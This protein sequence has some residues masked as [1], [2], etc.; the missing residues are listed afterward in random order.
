MQMGNPDIQLQMQ[1]VLGQ[2]LFYPP[3]VAG[4]PGGKDWIDGASLM[5]RM[6]IPRMVASRE[7]PSIRAKEDDDMEMGMGRRYERRAMRPLDVRVDW[8]QHF[9]SMAKVK[10]EELLTATASLLWQTSNL[11]DAPMLEKYLDTS[12]RETYIQSSFIRLMGSPEYQLC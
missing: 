12:T 1:R 6:Q 2:V 4:W 5:Y 7:M 10:R 8:N 3:N 11:P 9:S